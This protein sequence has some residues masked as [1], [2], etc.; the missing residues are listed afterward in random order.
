M[1]DVTHRPSFVNA[2]SWLKDVRDHAEEDAVVILVGNR[3]DLVEEDP[4]KRKVKEDEAKSWAQEQ[5]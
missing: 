4:S 5:G 2:Q 1:Y 3:V